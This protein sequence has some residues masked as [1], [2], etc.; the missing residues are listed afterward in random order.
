MTRLPRLMD[1]DLR[2]I[3]RLDVVDA[4]VEV[5]LSPLS[6]AEITLTDAGA[7]QV[8]QYVEMYTSS[9]S[10]GI[11]RVNTM[12]KRYGGTTT[13]TLEHGLCTL[14]DAIMTGKGTEK[15]SPRAMLARLLG[16]QNRSMWQLGTVEAPDSMVLTWE[17][18]Y[19]NVLEGLCE[20][21]DQLDGYFVSPD[22]TTTP[23]TLHLLK[24][25]DDDACECRLNRNLESV[26]VTED[27]SE[28]CTRLYV[29]GV[30]DP[31]NAD[32]QGV[33]GI[34]TRSMVADD[35]I[36]T[37]ALLQEGRAYLEKHK[38]PLISVEM[39][40]VDLM[41][42]TGE[43]FD[44][45]YLGRNCRVCLPEYKT[46][47]RHRVI[48]I[49]HPSIYQ[50]PGRVMVTLSHPEGSAVSVLAGLIV[51]TT[52]TRKRSIS[53]SGDIRAQGDL[54][55]GANNTLAL[56]AEQ[57]AV[58]AKQVEINADEI[59]LKANKIDLQGYVT[60]T[61]LE[62]ELAKFDNMLAGL[63]TISTLVVNNIQCNSYLAVG[64][65]LSVG[66][67][68]V[69]MQSKSVCTSASKI[70]AVGKTIINF[71][72]HSGNKQSV[73]VVIDVERENA[74]TSTIRYVGA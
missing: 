70:T 27:R 30:S 61:A 35:S 9:G 69:A 1:S 2:E 11:Y 36:G 7:V 23:W 18:D 37:D 22:Q 42:A 51:D 39:D 56:Y 62:A 74:P 13:V 53:N 66:G 47:L 25:A 8:G 33:W 48:R 38:T 21:L 72:D 10:A 6:T 19:S 52:V 3:G 49:S 5:N 67:V 34:V 59:L 24:L 50:E 58:L 65:T 41:E 12:D 4:S 71:V 63:S 15:G 68:Q 32:T 46:V 60:A 64:G 20:V 44:R 54:I 29:P 73:G 14:G 40:A 16:C 45:F 28:L 17:Y 55:I 43:S 26:T 57:L 31:L